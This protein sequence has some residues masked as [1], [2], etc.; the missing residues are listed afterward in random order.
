[1]KEESDFVS[2]IR[3]RR[4]VHPLFPLS[5]S[6]VTNSDRNQGLSAVHETEANSLALDDVR[7]DMSTDAIARFA[8]LCRKDNH[9]GNH[10]GSRSLVHARSADQL[11]IDSLNRCFHD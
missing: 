8:A 5:P 2:F 3:C 9:S 11:S 7:S 4:V 1:M 6:T 10:I